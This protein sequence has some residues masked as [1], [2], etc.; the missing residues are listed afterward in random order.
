MRKHQRGDVRALD[1]ESLSI[2][3]TCFQYHGYGRRTGLKI[4]SSQEGVGSSPTFGIKC[5][6]LSDRLRV[7]GLS[8]FDLPPANVVCVRGFTFGFWSVE[9]SLFPMPNLVHEWLAEWR[10]R[11]AALRAAQEYAECTTGRKVASAWPFGRIRA[12]TN[13]RCYVRVQYHDGLGSG[14]GLFAI[15]NSGKIEAVTA[16]EVRSV[17]QYRC[18]C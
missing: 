15:H 12:V 3:A 4:R 16:R 8:H 2:T 18:R 1:S 9:V 14:T 13:D 7:R 17:R 5:I 6:M 10:R 11:R